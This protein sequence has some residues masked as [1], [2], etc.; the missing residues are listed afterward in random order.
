MGL[1][2][3]A[4]TLKREIIFQSFPWVSK[5]DMLVSSYFSPFLLLKCAIIQFAN[6]ND[7]LFF[8]SNVT[9]LKTTLNY[10][11]FKGTLNTTL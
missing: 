3:T 4:K 7:N 10:A 2:F 5:S 11:T 8:P 6:I 1:S 9:V